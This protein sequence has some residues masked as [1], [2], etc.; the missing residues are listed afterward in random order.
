MQSMLT[1]SIEYEKDVGK[2]GRR[3]GGELGRRTGECKREHATE[4]DQHQDDDVKDDDN[5]DGDDEEETWR[6][7]RSI[8]LW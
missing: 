2:R 8:P 3:R 4:S 1:Q 7:T 6:C 5:D